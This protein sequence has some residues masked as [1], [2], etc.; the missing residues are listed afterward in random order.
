M[1]LRVT[2]ALLAAL[3]AIR[4]LKP[5]PYS[6]AAESDPARALHLQPRST[7]LRTAYALE[8]ERQAKSGEAEK[9]LLEAAANDRQFAPAWQLT[10]FYFRHNR[11]S[12]FFRW[13]HLA[14][15]RSYGDLGA[16]FRLCSL[17]GAST[18]QM[19]DR[20][21][22]TPA[23][24]RN[25]IAWLLEENRLADIEPVAERLLHRTLLA[26]EELLLVYVE[27]LIHEQQAQKAI[28][29]WRRIAP[30]QGL[31]TNRSF[32]SDL[33][34][35][36]FDWRPVP[37]DGIRQYRGEPEPSGSGGW[38]I[39]FSGRQP[40]ISDVLTQY[41]VLAPGQRYRLTTEAQPLAASGLAPNSFCWIV[42]GTELPLEKPAE[43]RATRELDQLV[44]R[45]RR[46]KGS[47]RFEGILRIQ[48]VSLELAGKP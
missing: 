22:V 36:G 15:E 14:A 40:E 16:L 12:E 30:S 1:I 44:L 27:R 24:E 13:A 31:V 25:Y 37:I 43:F 47:T 3:A 19:L 42:A 48:S 26:D 9:Q 2:F 32:S 45:C 34:G 38:R 41:V 28:A 7:R 10:D 4:A 20:I 11:P 18:E 17:S 39:D 46:P 29:V 33:L 6:P 21:L 5:W 35:R 8:L 23:I